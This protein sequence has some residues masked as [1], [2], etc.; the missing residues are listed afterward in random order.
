MRRPRRGPVSLSRFTPNSWFEIYRDAPI[1][2]RLGNFILQYNTIPFFPA[3][4][5]E[6]RGLD[7]NG[8]PL[9]IQT[10][11]GNV[12]SRPEERHGIVPVCSFEDGI[13]LNDTC[14]P[15][16]LGEDRD[17]AMRGV[18]YRADAEVA[19]DVL[20]RLSVLSEPYGTEFAIDDGI[21]T[22]RFD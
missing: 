12:T 16:D 2:Y 4:A 5:Y 10:E 7:T 6:S 20:E 3:E 14:H 21:G 11:I 1:F 9:E 18:A 22:L 8:T 15:V 19:T 17:E 13:L